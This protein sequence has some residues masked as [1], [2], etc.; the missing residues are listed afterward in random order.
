M[1]RLL[2][3]LFLFFVSC[4]EKFPSVPSGIIPMDKMEKMLAD[5]HISDAVASTRAMG[6]INEKKYTG[7]YYEQIFKNH[8]ITRQEFMKSYNFYENNPILLNKLYDDV[9]GDISK[10]EGNLS[11]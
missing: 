6:D 9:L 1:K 2:P 8:G 3:L 11:K 10:R 5:M 4:K 7:Q